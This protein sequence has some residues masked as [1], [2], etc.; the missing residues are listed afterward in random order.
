MT[1]ELNL[2]MHCG[3]HVAS[4]DEVASVPTP[5]PTDTWCPINHHDF[6]IGIKDA[7]VRSGLRV[8]GEAHGLAKNRNRYFGMLQLANGSRHEDYSLVVGIRNSHDKSF[9][10]G[11]VC[12]SGCFVCD[13]LAFSG[14]IR[15]SR[16]HTRWINRDL[17]HLISRAVGKLG[18]L[19]HKQDFRI[20]SYKMRSLSDPEAHDLMVRALDARVITST[21]IPKVVREWRNPRH[22][23]FKNRNVWSLFNSFTEV[24]KETSLFDRP[25][26][27][28][29]LH[30]LMDR[31]C[32]LN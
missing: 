32:E 6:L 22:D 16:K 27:T 17:P 19:R 31:A 23:E 3:G 14:E 25:R 18:D 2:A 8:V 4:R 10:A 30:G 1:T 20:A 5:E 15:I 29:A 7:L 13:N 11:L 28:M 24:M 26:R 12:G 21:R 9:P